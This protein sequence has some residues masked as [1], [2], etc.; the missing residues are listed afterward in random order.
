MSTD[1]FYTTTITVTCPR[2]GKRSR[3]LLREVVTNIITLCNHCP[4]AIDI[5]TPEWRSVIDAA[6]AGAHRHRVHAE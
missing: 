2:C 6:V 3:K 4:T 5:S 1:A